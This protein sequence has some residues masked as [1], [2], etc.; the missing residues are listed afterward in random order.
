MKGTEENCKVQHSSLKVYAS[1]LVLAVAVGFLTF[2]V[3][4]T[5]KEV[6]QLRDQLLELQTFSMDTKVNI[7]PALWLAVIIV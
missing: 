2:Y 1:L 5:V 4:H 7:K 6:N 3:F